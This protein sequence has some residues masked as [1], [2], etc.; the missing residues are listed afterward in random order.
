MSQITYKNT[1]QDII[2]FFEAHK[3]V[4]TVR[5]SDRSAF[6]GAKD[7]AYPFVFFEPAPSTMG[8]G[9]MVYSFEVAVMDKSNEARSDLPEIYSKC[10]DIISDFRVKFTRGYNQDFGVE[11]TEL[12]P[13]NRAGNDRVEGFSISVSFTVPGYADKC[14]IPQ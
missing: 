2:E 14:E 10:F 9:E 11:V 13:I 8:I 3:Q 4:N 5:F 12:L 6:E 7:K 1:V